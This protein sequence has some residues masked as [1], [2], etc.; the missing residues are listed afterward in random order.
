MCVAFGLLSD[1]S[2]GGE[3]THLLSNL[4]RH[5]LLS[6]YFAILIINNKKK[7]H[8]IA[9]LLKY[10]YERSTENPSVP[11]S[12]PGSTTTRIEESSN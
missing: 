7:T 5:N 4:L 2:K 1:I 8:I 10:L 3:D 9:I 11:R 12:G 6:C